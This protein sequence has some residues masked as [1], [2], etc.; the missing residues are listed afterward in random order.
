M[1]QDVIQNGYASFARSALL[2]RQ[3]AQLPPYLHLAIVR[4]ESL[5]PEAGP[6]WLAELAQGLLQQQAQVQLLGPLQPPLERRAGMHRWQLQLYSR[7]R[8][9]LHHA[10]H[11]VLQQISALPSTRQLKWQLDV[12]PLDLN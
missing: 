5:K 11:S 12:D 7:D 8:R 2:E 3:Q 10:L 6:A 4:T 9:H 1:L